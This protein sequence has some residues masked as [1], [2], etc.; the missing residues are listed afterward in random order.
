MAFTA[1]RPD[2]APEEAGRAAD[3][4][5]FLIDSDLNCTPFFCV[6]LKLVLEGAF[7]VPVLGAGTEGVFFCVDTI[8]LPLETGVFFCTDSFLGAVT[9]DAARTP[10][11]LPAILLEEDAAADLGD[12]FVFTK[13]ALAA[14]ADPDLEDAVRVPGDD[15]AVFRVGA[16]EAADFDPADDPFFAAEVVPVF[17]ADFAE[18]PRAGFFDLVVAMLP[19]PIQNKL[20]ILQAPLYKKYTMSCHQE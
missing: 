2:T 18:R 5:A 6:S 20:N 8:T 16:L 9:F 13:E 14:V 1:V 7:I 10:G 17:D 4:P 3:S 12:D 15:V 19:A 11:D